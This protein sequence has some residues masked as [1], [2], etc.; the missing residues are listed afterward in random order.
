MGHLFHKRLQS[1]SV[2]KKKKTP[3]SIMLDGKWTALLWSYRP[4]QAL[5]SGRS[6]H[7][8]SH[9]T[10][11]L[12]IQLLYSFHAHTLTEQPS[13]TVLGS[14]ILPADTFTLR[15]EEPGF[16]LPT[17]SSVEEDLSLLLSHSCLRPGHINLLYY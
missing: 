10:L 4:L 17:L 14:S 11:L 16:K 7:S 15:P 12:H 6:I 13:Q 5:Y 2:D 8:V 3:I 9:S 1:D